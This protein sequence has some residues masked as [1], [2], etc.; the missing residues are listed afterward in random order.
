MAITG[1]AT[2]N[3]HTVRAQLK[4]PEYERRIDPTGAHYPDHPKILR[5]QQSRSPGQIRSGIGAPV[6]GNAQYFRFK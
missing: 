5:I 3:Q 2:A 1:M 6:A 4:R